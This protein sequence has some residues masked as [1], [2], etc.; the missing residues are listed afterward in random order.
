MRLRGSF[1]RETER[2]AILDLQLLLDPNI[3]CGLSLTTRLL[4]PAD[5]ADRRLEERAHN[6]HSALDVKE[7]DD[8]D[9][10]IRC[11]F[12]LIKGNG[13]MFSLPQKRAWKLK[14]RRE[15]LVCHT[16]KCSSPP[17]LSVLVVIGM[18]SRCNIAA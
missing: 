6:L 18:E 5:G 7:T 10:V 13:L 4:L 2:H 16:F 17:Q 9:I 3:L 14:D 8:Q 1:S 12:S 15:R 11:M